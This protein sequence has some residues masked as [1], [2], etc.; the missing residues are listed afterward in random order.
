MERRPVSWLTWNLGERYRKVSVQ[1]QKKTCA[2]FSVVVKI[3]RKMLGARS[4]KEPAANVFRRL[5][6]LS[7]QHLKQFWKWLWA[8][9]SMVVQDQPMVYMNK[10]MLHTLLLWDMVWFKKKKIIPLNLQ[11]EIGK[12]KIWQLV[13]ITIWYIWKVRCLKVFQNVTERPA[14]IISGIW[15]E[16]V[17]NLK[18]FLVNIKGNT[19]RTELQTLEF[20]AIWDKYLS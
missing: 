5:T 13:S 20:Y 7:P 15:R 6:G 19:Q 4:W 16:I 12:P 8:V 2:F 11:I 14:Q 18:G 10:T 1:D 17:H 9:L 3:G